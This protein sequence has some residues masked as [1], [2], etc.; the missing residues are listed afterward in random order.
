MSSAQRKALGRYRDRQKTRGHTRMEISI[1]EQDREI[2]KEVAARL[3]AGGV[4]AENMRSILE[5]LNDPYAGMD[6][7]QFLEAAPIEELD[8]DRLADQTREVDL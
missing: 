4:V 8:L 2:M 1:P 5:S 6:F 7:K 3:R